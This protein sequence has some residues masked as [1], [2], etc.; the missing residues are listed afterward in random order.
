MI[1]F[2][3]KIIYCTKE[4]INFYMHEL[5]HWVVC[6]IGWIFKINTFPKLIITSKPI[7]KQNENNL[8][9][10]SMYGKVSLNIFDYKMVT[11]KLFLI[12]FYTA[13]TLFYILILYLFYDNYIILTYYIL[14]FDSLNMS[15]TDIKGFKK[16]LNDK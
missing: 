5:S 12:I 16:L 8:E 13:P 11:T 15:V 3:S 14:N 9:A 6:F 4:Y 7:Y 10:H 1:F 2:I